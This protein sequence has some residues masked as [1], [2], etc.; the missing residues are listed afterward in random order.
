MMPSAADI[1]L[2]EAIA[3]MTADHGV[4][5]MH[6]LDDG[7]QLSPVLSGDLPAEDDG[8]LVGLANGPVGVQQVFSYPIQRG[9]AAEDEVV[10]K[11]D[12]GEEQAMLATR[13]PAFP[14]GEKW[15]KCGQP[16]L[17]AGQ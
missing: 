5:Q 13:F 15:G 16:L 17:T 8:D 10:A 12:L 4:G 7:L 14:F 1:L 11:F 6:V 9:A 2:D 3:V